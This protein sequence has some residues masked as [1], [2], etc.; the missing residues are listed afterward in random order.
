M[1]ADVYFLHFGELKMRFTDIARCAWRRNN[2]SCLEVSIGVAISNIYKVCIFQGWLKQLCLLE[3]PVFIFKFRFGVTC[4][5]QFPYS[6]PTLLKCKVYFS[7]NTCL[8][9]LSMSIRILKGF[10]NDSSVLVSYLFAMFYSTLW[11]AEN[12]ISGNCSICL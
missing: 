9:T 8:T 10:E 6:G 4:D 5:S 12:A 11:R 3:T 7:L 2:F 1:F